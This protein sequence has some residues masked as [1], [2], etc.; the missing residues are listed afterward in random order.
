MSVARRR[1]TRSRWAESSC[2]RLTILSSST[3]GSTSSGRLRRSSPRS[4]SRLTWGPRIRRAG[5]VVSSR[6]RTTRATKTIH[7]T[8]WP[9]SV[10]APPRLASL[11]TPRSGDQPI[12]RAIHGGVDLLPTRVSV[13]PVQDLPRSLMEAHYG[14]V[15][16]DEPAHL[17]VVED[18]RGRLVPEKPRAP[19]RVGGRDL[20]GWHVNQTWFHPC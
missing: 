15:V 7:P 17:A 3:S 20:V 19:L 9:S 2:L 10:M 5:A 8:I 1:R 18:Q 16:G 4:T 6:A 12:H 13:V 14:G 11:R